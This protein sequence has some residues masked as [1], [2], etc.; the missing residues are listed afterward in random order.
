MSGAVPIPNMTAT[1]GARS[2]NEQSVNVGGG[3]L[4]WQQA[5]KKDLLTMENLTAAALV[6]AAAYVFLKGRK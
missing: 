4:W 5:P 1:S 6:M 3:A 2:A